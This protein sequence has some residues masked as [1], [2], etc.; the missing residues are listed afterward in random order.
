VLLAGDQVS[1][2]ASLALPDTD[3]ELERLSAAARGQI[4]YLWSRRAENERASSGVFRWIAEALREEGF[5]PALIQGATRA[6]DDE[7]LHHAVCRDVAARYTTDVPAVPSVATPSEP[8]FGTCSRRQARL[9]AISLQCAINESLSTA[10]L[11]ACLDAARGA[12]ARAGLRRLLKDEVAHARI[13]WGSLASPNV[14]QRDRESLARHLPLLLDLSLSTW[15]ADDA[16]YPDDL[17][18]GHGVVSYRVIRDTALASVR[19]VVLPGFA[20][21]GVD[22]AHGSRFFA[23]RFGGLGSL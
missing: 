5:A 7:L 17:P 10:Y 19:D 16:D 14:T 22:I 1:R 23:Q 3:A 12:S 13:G 4:A 20:H 15:L 8:S 9:L 18:G 6:I 11:G 2:A 21:V